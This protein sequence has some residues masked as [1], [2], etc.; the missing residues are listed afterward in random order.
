MA[1]PSRAPRLETWS[2]GHALASLFG[3]AVSAALGSAWPLCATSLLSFALLIVQ[4]RGAFTPAGKFG[5]P[6]ALTTLRLA[7]AV[8]VGL[9]ARVSHVELA[10]LVLAIFALDGLDGAWA[11]RSGLT[12]AFGAHFDME[13]D[14]TFVMVVELALWQR[15]LFGAWI[16]T[17]GLLRYVYVACLALVRPRGGEMPRTRLGRY[18]FAVLVLGLLGGLVLPAPLSL[19]FAVLGTS[20]VSLSFARSFYWSYAPRRGS[21]ADS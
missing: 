17:T 18:A 15:G 8:S 16:L 10:V 21:S 13:V 12:G 7:L 6:N 2:R 9:W 19:G 20:A 14:A 11:R 4:S 1:E 5:G 3:V